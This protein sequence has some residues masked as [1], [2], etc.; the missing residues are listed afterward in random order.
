M[1]KLRW[2]QQGERG[3]IQILYDLVTES[4][5]TENQMTPSF[6]A[7]LSRWRVGIPDSHSFKEKDKKECRLE[8]E[9]QRQ[10]Q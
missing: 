9:R 2:Y 8:S 6:L 10:S 5:E 7:W 4:E 3:E 1:S